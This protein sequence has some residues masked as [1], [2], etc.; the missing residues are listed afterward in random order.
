MSCYARSRS[1]LVS[2]FN[3]LYERD[4]I[5]T[6]KPIYTINSG[7]QTLRA[8]AECFCNLL[9]ALALK[10]KQLSLVRLAWCAPRYPKRLD[11]KKMPLKRRRLGPKEV[12]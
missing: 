9:W 12:S 3:I 7:E 6:W 2:A 11:L 1:M 8:V 10:L 4:R 5:D